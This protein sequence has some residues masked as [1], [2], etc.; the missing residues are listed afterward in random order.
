[1]IS[2]PISISSKADVPEEWDDLVRECPWGSFYPSSCSLQILNRVSS[3]KIVLLTA[4]NGAGKLVGGLAMGVQDGPLGSVMNS[5]P[6]FG[7]YGDAIVSPSAPEQTEA[8]LYRGALAFCREIDAL[9]FTVITSPFA[10]PAHH[11]NVRNFISPTFVDERCCQIAHL[12]PYQGEGEEAYLD[13]ILRKMQSRAR[14][15][16][17]KNMKGE[18]VI[19]PVKTEAEALEFAQIHQENIGE[20][21]GLWKTNAFFRLVFSISSQFPGKAELAITRADGRIAAGLL[22]F[23]FK[24]TTEYY[25]PCIRKE[26]SPVHPLRRMI[27][28]KMVEAGIAGHRFWNFGGTW[29]SQ[30]GL[31]QFKKSF[32]AEDHS[33]FYFTK[34]F[35]RLEDVRVLS[36]EEIMRNYPL[37]YVIPFS[38]LKEKD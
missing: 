33:Y 24:D 27:V 5:L 34:F 6:Y 29:K 28:R 31:Y 22:L 12:P 4:R 30:H 13:H 32:G 37:C 35:R 18:F 2:H 11:G 16:Y 20:K 36:P 19:D 1:M 10:P 9:C 14:T 23:H 3:A 25:T 17:R 38:E 26:Y 15:T 7:S 21:G 8:E